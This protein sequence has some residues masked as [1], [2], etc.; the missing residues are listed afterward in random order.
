MSAPHHGCCGGGLC[1][2]SLTVVLASD[3]VS[4]LQLCSW[5]PPRSHQASPQLGGGCCVPQG[6]ESVP[7]R[8][9]YQWLNPGGT[10][11]FPPP[12]QSPAAV[13][14]AIALSS[15]SPPQPRTVCQGT[16]QARVLLAGGQTK[17]GHRALRL[18]LVRG[19]ATGIPAEGGR[20]PGASTLTALE[21]VQHG[22]SHFPRQLVIPTGCQNVPADPGCQQAANLPSLPC[23][24][25]S[26][27]EEIKAASQ[28]SPQPMS[29]SDFLDKLMG[30]T[31][32]YDARIRPNFKG[33]GRT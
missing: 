13:H 21:G 7:G 27:R 15:L 23:S 32:G 8:V 24:L 12:A 11:R 6:R 16:W 1:C 26:G 3:K 17:H 30:R 22:H 33:K 10:L 29:P 28:G 9:W 2:S 14:E 19:E 20:G 25:V 18:W 5:A 31:S 4:E